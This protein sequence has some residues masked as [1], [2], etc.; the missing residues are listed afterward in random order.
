MQ[1]PEPRRSEQ[2]HLVLTVTLADCAEGAAALEAH[3]TRAP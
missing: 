1:K 3:A 2:G